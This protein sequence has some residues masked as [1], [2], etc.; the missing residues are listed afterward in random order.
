MCQ[1]LWRKQYSRVSNRAPACLHGGC[2]GRQAGKRRGQKTSGHTCP[3]PAKQKM[4]G[5][6]CK[7]FLFVCRKTIAAQRTK[8]KRPPRCI[9]HDKSGTE[10]VEKKSERVSAKMAVGKS[11]TTNEYFSNGFAF[12]NCHARF[13]SI[14]GVQLLAWLMS[15]GHRKKV[16]AH[17]SYLVACRRMPSAG[18]HVRWP[19]GRGISGQR[20]SAC[21][22]LPS[23]A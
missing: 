17:R 5:H 20:L 1:L 13:F 10:A 23:I 4:C 18:R 14:A 12:A 6:A 15:R 21:S 16:L 19:C 8:N 3:T 9:R 7:Y 11:K 2:G 22:N